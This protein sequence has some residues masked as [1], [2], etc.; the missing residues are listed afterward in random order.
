MKKSIYFLPIMLIVAY[1]I[2]FKNRLNIPFWA[3]IL[4]SIIF[5]LFTSY[6]AYKSYQ[7]SEVPKKSIIILAIVVLSTTAVSFLILGIL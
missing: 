6:L 4:V 7:S 1:L 3:E 5:I 2:F